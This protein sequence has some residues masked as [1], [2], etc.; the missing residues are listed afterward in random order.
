MAFPTLFPMRATIPNQPRMKAVQLHEY[1]LHLIR[2]YDNR[3]ANHPR[4]RYYIYNIMMWHRN[5]AITSIFMKKN[6][7]DNFPI[8][9]Q[10][11]NIRLEQFPD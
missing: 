5:Q 8:S 7:T 11:L 3:F 10:D 6:I 2:Y 1:A 4:F 9:I